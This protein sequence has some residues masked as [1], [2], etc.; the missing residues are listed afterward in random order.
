LKSLKLYLVSFRDR[1]VFYEALVNEVLD[2]LVRTLAPRSLT[3][4]GRFAV[5][6]GISSVVTASHPDARAGGRR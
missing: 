4:E 5:R 6:G 1:G 3:V 2:D